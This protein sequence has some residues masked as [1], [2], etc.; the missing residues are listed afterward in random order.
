MAE[1][2]SKYPFAGGIYVWSG[3]IGL[4]KYSPIMA[5]F[6][7]NFICL[8]ALTNISTNAFGAA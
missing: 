8:G 3:K 1:A 4:P 6:S 5:Y 7:G 2:C